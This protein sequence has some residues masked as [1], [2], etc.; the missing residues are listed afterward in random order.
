VRKLIVGAVM[1]GAVTLGISYPAGADPTCY[2]ECGPGPETV[3]GSGPS[4]APGGPISQPAPAPELAPTQSVP[5]SGGLP[6]TGGDIEQSAAIATVALVAGVA[7]V[8]VGRRKA[9]RAS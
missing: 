6:L 1:A 2:T 7:M 5:S 8:R 3:L 4:T 9:A